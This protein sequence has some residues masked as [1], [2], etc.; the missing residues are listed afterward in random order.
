[1]VESPK[2]ANKQVMKTRVV[3]P[4]DL[5]LERRPTQTTIAYRGQA[6][7]TPDGVQVGD[8]T[9]QVVE[10]ILDDL[11]ASRRVTLRGPALELPAHLTCYEVHVRRWREEREQ[12]TKEWTRWI[13]EDPV[14]TGALQD[15]GELQEIDVVLEGLR[16]GGYPLLAGEIDPMAWASRAWKELDPIQRAIV[17]SLVRRYPRCFAFSVALALGGIDTKQYGRAVWRVRERVDG[18][19]RKQDAARQLEYFEDVRRDAW[20]AERYVRSFVDELEELFAHGESETLEFKSTLRKNLMADK[21]DSAIL[22][23]SLKSVAGFLNADGE[24]WR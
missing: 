3:N 4:L 24:Y 13:R 9:Q 7:M 8:K 22:Q 23:V 17:G 11:Q 16:D 6:L 20:I 5:E 14:L 21:I 19:F 12:G 15:A 2:A 1:M 10:I 18:V